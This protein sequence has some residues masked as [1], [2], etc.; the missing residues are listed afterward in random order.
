[1]KQYYS[2]NQSSAWPLAHFTQCHQLRTI[3][4]LHFPIR[5]IGELRLSPLRITSLLLFPLA[6]SSFR[7]NQ[8]TMD[9]V[10]LKDIDHQFRTKPKSVVSQQTSSDFGIVPSSA[11]SP[12]MGNPDANP[13]AITTPDYPLLRLLPTEIILV[14]DQFL[15][16][17]FRAC[18]ALTCTR[19]RYIL[20][21]SAT[22]LTFQHRQHTFNTLWN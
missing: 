5:D 20:P 16:P 15:G 14:I 8:S 6:I 7:L 9:R 18:F 21:S 12:A 22:S 13:E 19:I 10:H 11:S 4:P 1:M 2:Q 17:G 3:T